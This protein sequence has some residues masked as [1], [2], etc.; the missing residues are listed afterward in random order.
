MEH[1][2]QIVLGIV[3]AWVS[4]FALSAILVLPWAIGRGVRSFM[5]AVGMDIRAA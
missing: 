1:P 2:V 4:G 5:S 3:V